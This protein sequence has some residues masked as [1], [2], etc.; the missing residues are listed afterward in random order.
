V[1]DKLK[2]VREEEAFVDPDTGLQLGSSETTIGTIE[3]VEA[4][5]KFSKAKVLSGK[6]PKNKDLVRI[7]IEQK[8]DSKQRG[9][10]GKQL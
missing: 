2:V 8:P 4:N 1:G 9:K 7:I 6:I 10:I 3:I 5:D